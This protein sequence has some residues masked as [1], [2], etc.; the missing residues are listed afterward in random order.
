M[1]GAGGDVPNGAEGAY[2]KSGCRDPAHTGHPSPAVVWA[3]KAVSRRPRGKAPGKTPQISHLS[4]N[5]L[6]KQQGHLY[7]L[8]YSSKL[9]AMLMNLAPDSSPGMADILKN[10]RPATYPPLPHRLAMEGLQGLSQVGPL[11]LVP[12]P[13]P[14]TVLPWPLY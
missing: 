2:R 12:V 1:E 10:A 4:F 13:D 9:S 11:P 5:L 3:L 8:P 7:L 14:L 6:L